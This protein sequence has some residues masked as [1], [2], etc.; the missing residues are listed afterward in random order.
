MATVLIADDDVDHREL[1]TL[2]LH[3]FG[4]EVVVAEDADSAVRAAQG[5]GID[6]VLLD[7]RMPGASGIVVCGRLRAAPETANLPIMMV[8][9]DVSGG[10]IMAAMNAGADDYLTKPFHRSELETRLQ[11]LLVRRERSGSK[12]CAAANAALLAARAAV[13]KPVSHPVHVPLRRIA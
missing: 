3:R 10:R 9:A 7:M 5:G 11:A 8:S 2:A 4:H 6:A 13:G 1:M 12:P